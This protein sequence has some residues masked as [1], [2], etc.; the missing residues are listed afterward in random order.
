VAIGLGG[1]SSSPEKLFIVPLYALK[2]NFVYLDYLSKFEKD[3]NS[4]FF[5]SNKTQE[6]K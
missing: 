6:L 3:V 4:D 2:Y 1:K 5:F